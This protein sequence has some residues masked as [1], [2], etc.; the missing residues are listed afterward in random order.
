MLI[1]IDRMHLIVPSDSRD[2]GCVVLVKGAEVA[3]EGELVGDS[4]GGGGVVSDDDDADLGGEE[5]AEVR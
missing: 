3:A 1:R 2:S 4:E 5:G